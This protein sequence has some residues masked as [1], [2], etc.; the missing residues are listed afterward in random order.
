[1][2]LVFIVCMCVRVFICTVNHTHLEFNG[3]NIFEMEMCEDE[4]PRCL[5][6]DLRSTCLD[7]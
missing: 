2:I 6:R 1:M 3:F 7:R 4:L 5:P